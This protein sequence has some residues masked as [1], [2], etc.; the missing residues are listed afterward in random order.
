M[1]KL[2]CKRYKIGNGDQS[3]D[4]RWSSNLFKLKLSSDLKNIDAVF[5]FA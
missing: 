2:K 5:V 1:V 4:E 3:K